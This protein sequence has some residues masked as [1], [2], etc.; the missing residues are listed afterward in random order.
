MMKTFWMKMMVMAILAV[1]AAV[2]PAGC[3]LGPNAS[4]ESGALRL[5]LR[6]VEPP[7]IVYRLTNVSREPVRVWETDNSWGWWNVT[8]YLDE[9][10][11]PGAGPQPVFR[12]ARI[13]SIDEPAY[14]GIAPGKHRDFEIDLSSGEWTIPGDVDWAGKEYAAEMIFGIDQTP[15]SDRHGVYVGRMR[16]WTERK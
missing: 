16:V 13:R 1:A 10:E 5:T 14:F 6:S 4:A 7:K 3:A 12:V 15:A 8:V 2:I 9:K 11:K